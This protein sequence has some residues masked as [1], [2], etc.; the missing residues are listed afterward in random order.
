MLPIII[1]ATVQSIGAESA[2]VQFC[3]RVPIIAPRS[4]RSG[5]NEPIATK[6]PMNAKNILNEEN[7]DFSLASSDM[8]PNIAP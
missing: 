5:S 4:L 3:G 7:I 8:T 2:M 1:N 6:L